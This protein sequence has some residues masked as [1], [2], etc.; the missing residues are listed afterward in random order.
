MPK[1]K[2]PEN[3][4]EGISPEG[5][6]PNELLDKIQQCVLGIANTTELL[7]ALKIDNPLV[8]KGYKIKMTP[9]FLKDN[10]E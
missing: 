8:Y 10:K 9:D 1:N 3:K 2:I 5:N 7:L 4:L 6:T